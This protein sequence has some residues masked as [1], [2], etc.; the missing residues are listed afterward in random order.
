MARRDKKSDGNLVLKLTSVILAVLLELYFFSPDNSVTKS[1]TVDLELRGLPSDMMVVEPRRR[2][3]FQA[4]LKIR[5]PSPLVDQVESSLE[6][7]PITA[8]SPLPP[9]YK[10]FLADYVKLPGGV[11][12]LEVDPETF[13]LSFERR[14]RKEVVV[15]L[16]QKGEVADGFVIDDIQIRPQAVILTGPQSEVEEIAALETEKLDLSGLKESVTKTVSLVNTRGLTVPNVDVI[17]VKITVRP[18]LDEKLFKGLGLGLQAPAGFAASAEP[19]KVDVFVSGPAMR[20]SGLN[21]EDIKLSVDAQSLKTGNHLLPVDVS[22]PDGF[23]LV[24][25]YPAQVKITVFSS[26]G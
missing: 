6:I 12:L 9:S 23:E 24:R 14:V 16:A 19:S 3:D 2:R 5:G 15:V 1:L 11:Q 17:T 18:I 8:V 10:V 13:K 26:D 7:L 20:L 25:T 21:P 22:L 4:E